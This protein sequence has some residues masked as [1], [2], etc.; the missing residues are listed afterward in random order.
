MSLKSKLLRL[1]NLLE[2]HRPVIVNH[3]IV[4]LQYSALLAGRCAL[5]TG[6][7]SGI[8]LS[9]AKSMLYAGAHVVIAGR[10]LDKLALT[11]NIIESTDRLDSKRLLMLQLDN[12]DTENFS[13]ILDDFKE[14]NPGVQIDILINNAGVGGGGFNTT[15]EKEFDRVIDTNLKSAFF[16]SRY[17]SNMWIEKGIKGNILNI[18]SSSALRPAT[19]AYSLSK[20]GINGLTVGLAKKLSRYGITVNAIAPGPTVTPM[21]VKDGSKSIY[22]SSSPI[23][24]YILPEE[25]ANMAVFLTSE[26]GRSI[27]GTTVYMTGGAGTITVDD[28]SY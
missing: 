21:L 9:I 20:W 6:G 11:R 3:T 26:M 5:V 28:I 1:V 4:E 8:G 25:I 7:T 27:V 10:N 22:L 24:R 17:F 16:L 12:C 14:H 23:G 13:D 15:D 19:S 18:S 2:R